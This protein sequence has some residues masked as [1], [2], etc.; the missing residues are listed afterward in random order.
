MLKVGFNVSTVLSAEVKLNE[1]LSVI[2]ANELLE[3]SSKAVAS[4]S[5]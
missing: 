3:E 4:I 1:V 5:T 2:P